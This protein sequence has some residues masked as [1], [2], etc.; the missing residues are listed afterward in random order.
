MEVKYKMLKAAAVLSAACSIAACGGGSDS[1][2]DTAPVSFT[3]TAT[4]GAGGTISPGD[5]AVT[6]GQSTSFTVSAN[7]GYAIA[8]VTGCGG[9]LNGA[10]FTTASISAACTVTAG[11]EQL[12]V[13]TSLLNGKVIDGYVSGATVWLDINGNGVPDE[14]EPSTVSITAGDYALELTEEQRACVPYATLYVDVPVGAVDEDSGEVTAAYQMARPAQFQPLDEAALLHISPLTSVL[15]QQVQAQ[16][17]NNGQQSLSCAAL[18]A[19]SELGVQISNEVKDII[20]TTVSKYNIAADK[21]FADFIAADDEASYQLAQSIVKGLKATY[22][23]KQQLRQQHPTA[24]YIRSQFYQGSDIDNKNA[25]PQAWYRDTMLSFDT[26]YST[27]LVKMNNE[28]TEVVREIYLR[29]NI[30]T[31]WGDG[32]L[33]QTKDIYSYGGDD[34]EYS[35]T[36]SEAVSVIVN[37]ISYGLS[38]D[39][40]SATAASVAQCVNTSFSNGPYKYYSVDYVENA[41]GY[42]TRFVIA[43]DTAEY[44]TFVQ[45]RDLKTKAETLDLADLTTHLN[46]SGYKFDEEVLLDVSSWHKRSTD[47]RTTNRVQV[48]KFSDQPWEKLVYQAN[49]TY[50]KTCSTDNGQSWVACN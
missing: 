25:Y 49:G 35:C 3:V 17:S 23:Y 37:G 43:A 41:V 14:N 7:D 30:K 48:G 8:S 21:I 6:T 47:D 26:G 24:N 19:N 22:A 1:S 29:E 28:L 5:R 10:T 13:A 39:G 46:N 50:S 42:H 12:P 4:A 18:M 38:N 44:Q 15:W 40:S 45:W 11:F 36:N 34:A 9:T 20:Q 27:E 16:L 2:T 31:T 33:S 32:V